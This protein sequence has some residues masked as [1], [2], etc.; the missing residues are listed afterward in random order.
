M[1]VG[2]LYDFF[3]F[4]DQST[5]DLALL[6]VEGVADK[7]SKLLYRSSLEILRKFD[8]A[9]DYLFCFVFYYSQ[10]KLYI[11]IYM[12]FFLILKIFL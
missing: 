3:F 12:F 4:S 9:E 1:L 10:F 8:D 6:V 2:F 11:Y 7:L 5:V